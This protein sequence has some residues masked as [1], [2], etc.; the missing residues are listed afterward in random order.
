MS[1]GSPWSEPFIRQLAVDK[2]L[3]DEFVADQVRT[4]I[5]LAVRAMREQGSRR[6]SQAKLGKIMGKPQSVVSRI[7]DPDYG[8][9]SLQTLLDVAAALDVPVLVEFPEWEDWFRKIK[10]VKK[11]DLERR[12]FD[13]DHLVAQTRPIVRTESLCHI[14]DAIKPTTRSDISDHLMF[15]QA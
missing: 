2:E 6:L 3:R 13:A 8:K 5:G 15:A 4:R 7:E 12:A 10:T 1:S 9:H 11:A 14:S